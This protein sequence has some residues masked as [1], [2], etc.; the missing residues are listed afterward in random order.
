M[1]L[2][3]YDVGHKVWHTWTD[4]QLKNWL[5][6]HNVIKSNAQI[7]RGKLEKLVSYVVLLEV[8]C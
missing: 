2:F 1:K 6:E 8:R 3:Y 5:V 7:N 4:S